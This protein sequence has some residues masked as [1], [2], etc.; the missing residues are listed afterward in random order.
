ML[1]YGGRGHLTVICKFGEINNLSIGN[2]VVESACNNLIGP[3]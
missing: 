1:P 2:G 3:D